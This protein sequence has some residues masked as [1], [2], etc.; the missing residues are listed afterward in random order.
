[1]KNQSS[2]YLHKK[3]IPVPLY[4]GYLVILITNSE[5]LLSKQIHS[6]PFRDLFAHTV[7]GEYNRRQ[8]FFII[9]NFNNQYDARI[10]NGTIAHEALHATNFILKNR[11][12]IEDFN[13]DEP[14][15][16]LLEWIVHQVHQFVHD[17]GFKLE[18]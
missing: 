6:E 5:N 10:T 8:G 16:Y 2:E 12:V 18:I 13:N 14:Q 1:M 9:L 7:Y 3:A 15:A 11:G 17:K 4:R